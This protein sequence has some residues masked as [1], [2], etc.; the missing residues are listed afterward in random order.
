[1][2]SKYFKQNFVRERKSISR[3]KYGAEIITYPESDW[4]YF[5]GIINTLSISEFKQVA[6]GKETIIGSHKLYCPVIDI[7]ET[8][9]IRFNGEYYEIISIKNPMSFNRHLEIELKKID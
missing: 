7:K 1:M 6:A 2:I 8:D 9:R 5:R 3:D 4:L